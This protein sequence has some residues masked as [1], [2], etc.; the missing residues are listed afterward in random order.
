MKSKALSIEKARK[1]AVT[2]GLKR[3]LKSVVWFLYIS[4]AV[5]WF[6]L[7]CVECMRCRLLLLMFALS[8]CLSVCLPVMRST[9]R[10]MQCVQGHLLQ[11][12]PNHFGCLLY[13][14]RHCQSVITFGF[15]RISQLLGQLANACFVSRIVTTYCI[16]Y[17][18]LFVT[19]TC[20]TGLALLLLC[21]MSQE[22]W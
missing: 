19:Y 21:G 1:E 2:D 4:L 6:L 9:Q 11:P 5:C 12:L 18:V 22:F 16:L 7:G 10:H 8:V 13:T 15:G 20:C 17:K 14:Y 3:A